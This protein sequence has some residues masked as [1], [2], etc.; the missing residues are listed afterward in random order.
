MRTIEAE[1][2]NAQNF[3]RIAKGVAALIG[4]FVAIYVVTSVFVSVNADEIVV[5]QTPYYGT[6]HWYK[7]PGTYSQYWGKV[8]RYKKRTQFWF[9]AKNDQG[10]KEDQSIKIRFNDKGHANLSGSLAWEMPLDDEHLTQLHTKYNSQQAIEQQLVRTVVERSVYMTGPLMSSQESAAERRNELLQFV[11]DQ[12]SNGIYKTQTIQEKQ[13]DPLTGV[14]KTVSVVK[15]VMDGAN[16]A[17]SDESPLKT[18]GIRT[19]N[20]SINEIVYDPVVEAQ[21][22]EQQKATMAVTTAAANAKKAEQDTITAGKNGEAKAAEAKWAQEVI[23]VKEVTAAEQRLAVAELDT[24]AAAQTKAKLI[25]EGEGEARKRQLVMEA[26]GALD[27]KLDAYVKTQQFWADAVKN[28]QGNWMP[29]VSSGSQGGSQAG[30]GAMQLLEMMGA[31]AA[32][33]LGLDLKAS[34]AGRTTKK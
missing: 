13:P 17:R 6:L 21:I 22:Q 34:G 10:Q 7:Q 4:L 29:L 20:P 33:D 31:K 14:L 30:S 5:V 18:F 11:E 9:S 24:K 25:L 26:D 1:L 27:R 23:K 12:V 2:P 15:L 8:T 3:S 28:Y 32:V 19:F 16:I